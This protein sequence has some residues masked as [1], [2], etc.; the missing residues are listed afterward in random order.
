MFILSKTLS[1]VH[2]KQSTV[3]SFKEINK[4]QNVIHGISSRDGQER[5][6]KLNA[7]PLKL[8]PDWLDSADDFCD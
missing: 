6:I 2:N 4:T 5:R 8:S 3:R 1:S 7:Q